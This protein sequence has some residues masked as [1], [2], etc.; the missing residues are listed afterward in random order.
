MTEKQEN[1][2]LL[3]G[4]V[5]FKR[6]NYNPT[7]DAVWLAAYIPQNIKNVLDVGIGT[8]G[9][10]LC[11]LSHNPKLDIIGIDTSEQ[12]LQECQ[13]NIEL[14]NTNIQ[15]KQQDINNWHTTKTF[16]LVITNPPYFQGTPAKHNAHHNANIEDWV[17][18]CIARVKPGGYFCII[19]DVLLAHKIISKLEQKHFGDI[20]ILPLFGSKNIAE[21][22]LIRAKQGVKTGTIIFQSLSMN[23]DR[24]LRT[25]LTIDKLFTTLTSL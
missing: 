21:R 7:S 5:I 4:K 3:N 11:L 19:S 9:V 6:G 17:K 18:N 15:L 23:D 14:N 2:T 16:D 8:G 20:Q 22:V 13:K 12:M 10:S 24:I 1:F 25:G